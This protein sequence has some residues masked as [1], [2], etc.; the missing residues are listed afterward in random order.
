MQKG[1]ERLSAR[2]DKSIYTEAS[3]KSTLFRKKL[4]YKETG[5]KKAKFVTFSRLSDRVQ[6][7]SQK[8]GRR[9]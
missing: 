7:S 1:N 4:I 8:W 5:K 9:E 6:E 3:E 2:H